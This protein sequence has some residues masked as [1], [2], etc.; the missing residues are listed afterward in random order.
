MVRQDSERRHGQRV[1]RQAWRLRQARQDGQFRTQ[2][3]IMVTITVAD[4]ADTPAIRMAIVMADIRTA[5]MQEEGRVIALVQEAAAVAAAA[6]R[7]T[8][9]WA[10]PDAK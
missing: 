9:A 4:I 6:I 1:P 8:A 2:A 5:A 7:A 3:T 10:H